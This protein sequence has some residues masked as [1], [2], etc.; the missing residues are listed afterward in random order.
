M[1][2]LYRVL[3]GSGVPTLELILDSVGWGCGFLQAKS[4]P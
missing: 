4:L 1:P 3:G 2:Y